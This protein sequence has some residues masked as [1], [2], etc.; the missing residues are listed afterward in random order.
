M[1]ARVCVLD[2]RFKTLLDFQSPKEPGHYNLV[3]ASQEELK[4]YAPCWTDLFCLD[5]ASE[6][7][8]PGFD[9]LCDWGSLALQFTKN[10]QVSPSQGVAD[11][12]YS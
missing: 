10:C 3:F 6:Q 8:C 2:G 12:R 5:A 9:Q 1:G 4:I 7:I 11:P